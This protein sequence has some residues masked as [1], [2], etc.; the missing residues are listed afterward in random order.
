MFN[1]I[2]LNANNLKQLFETFEC[3]KKRKKNDRNKS[4]TIQAPQL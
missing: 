1:S 3:Q 4:K 2:L